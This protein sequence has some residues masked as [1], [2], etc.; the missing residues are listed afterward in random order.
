MLVSTRPIFLHRH[1]NDRGR[2]FK[3][4]HD[5]L[6]AMLPTKTPAYSNSVGAKVFEEYEDLSVQELTLCDIVVASARLVGGVPVGAVSPSPAATATATHLR[7][8]VRLSHTLSVV[9]AD[10]AR[11]AR[12]QFSA[13]PAGSA[14]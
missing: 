7:T 9:N 2:A 4:C 8:D 11:N 5:V 1:I 13:G 10:Q 3:S 14:L 12:C 6:Y